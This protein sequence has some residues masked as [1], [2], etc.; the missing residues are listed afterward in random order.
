MS[1]EHTRDVAEAVLVPLTERARAE[2]SRESG[3]RVALHRGRYWHETQPGFY[4]PVHLLARLRDDEA[5]RPARLCWG[6]HAS[7]RDEDAEH[8]N[9]TLPL[10]WL[11]DVSAYEEGA[12]SSNRRYQL[13]KAR[14]LVEIVEIVDP[15][16]L[17]EEGYD[18]LVSALARTGF[19]KPPSRDEYVAEL[20]RS[21]PGRRFV[22][23]GF[24]DG[25][26]AGYVEGFAVDG[27]AYLHD[28]VIATEALSTNVSTALQVEFVHA[29]ARSQ[30]V[31][32]LVHGTHARDDDALTMYKE[33]IGFPVRHVPARMSMLPGALPVIRWRAPQVAYRLVG[34]GSA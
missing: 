9:A 17:V 20:R 32:E 28:V 27:V 21:I 31:H 12:L 23:G 15:A 11:S 25:K 16:P 29:C 10:H 4:R 3:K 7:L 1:G 22:V 24:R 33:R 18:V 14:R 26:L 34:R 2:W 5:T 19:A 6:F 30:G 13:R 8:A